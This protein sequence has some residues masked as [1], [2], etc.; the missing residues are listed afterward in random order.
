MIGTETSR[1]GRGIIPKRCALITFSARLFV[2]IAFALPACVYSR[3]IPHTFVSTPD[4]IRSL[5]RLALSLPWVATGFK[6]TIGIIADQARSTETMRH[7]LTLSSTGPRLRDLPDA[8][9]DRP[10]N[11]KPNPLHPRPPCLCDRSCFGAC[12]FREL[13]RLRSPHPPKEIKYHTPCAH[14]YTLCF[15]SMRWC[16]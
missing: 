6:M 10:I 16:A 14:T 4:R 3:V 8:A 1:S 2:W 13:T 9:D 15:A 12:A 7:I 11:T 5:V